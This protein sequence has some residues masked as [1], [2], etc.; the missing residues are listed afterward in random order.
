M[1]AKVVEKRDSMREKR[2]MLIKN[3]TL[4]QAKGNRKALPRKEGRVREEGL[5]AAPTRP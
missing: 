1:N 2:Y 4:S 3:E 5:R